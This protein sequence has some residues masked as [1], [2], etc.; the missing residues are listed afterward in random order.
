MA[1]AISEAVENILYRAAN[2]FLRNAGT[3][4]D[5]QNLGVVRSVKV[6]SSKAETSPDTSGRKTQIGLDIT[7][8]FTLAQTSNTEI[9]ALDAAVF[10]TM[11]DVLITAEPHPGNFAVGVADANLASL[12]NNVL[13]QDVLVNADMDLDHMGN[14]SRIMFEVTWRART[15]DLDDFP[16][17][18]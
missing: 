8:S 18:P 1:I 10:D 4:D 11:L 5:F 15:A 2:V 16:D 7:A 14:E 6:T 17:E 9:A 3:T 12:T 13:V